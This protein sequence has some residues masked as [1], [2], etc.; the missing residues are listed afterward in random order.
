MY[1]YQY[2]CQVPDCT[3]TYTGETARNLYTRSLEHQENYLKFRAKSFMRTHQVEK[4]NDEPANFK[5]KV[6]QA[7]SDPLSRQ[8]AESIFISRTNGEILNAKSE[9]HQ[10]SIVKIR[11]EITQG[12]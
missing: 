1:Q 9:F 8:A 7:F 2:K 12:L 10:P 5:A 4:H 3:G 11:R 6:L